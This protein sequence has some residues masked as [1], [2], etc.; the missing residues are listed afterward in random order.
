MRH[1]AVRRSV[2]FLISL[3]GRECIRSA[4][5]RRLH[6]R[7]RQVAVHVHPRDGSARTPLRPGSPDSP[8]NPGAARVGE[9]PFENIVGLLQQFGP[10]RAGHVTVAIGELREQPGE[11]QPFAHAA[12]PP[13][14]RWSAE[15][16]APHTGSMPAA[17]PRGGFLSSINDSRPPF[18]MRRS[19][20]GATECSAA[21]RGLQPRLAP[22]RTAP[23]QDGRSGSLGMR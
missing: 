23:A 8:S 20:G 11:E 15:I 14:R 22:Q 19:S 13:V 3:K 12:E 7:A 21:V 10:Q 17:I 9:K 16:Q 1:L 18:L 4:K 2:G 5:A 6:A